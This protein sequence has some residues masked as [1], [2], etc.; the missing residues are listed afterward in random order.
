MANGLD[1]DLKRGDIK[2]VA[3][4]KD[5]LGL[6]CVQAIKII[7]PIDLDCPK[8]CKEGDEDCPPPPPPPPPPPCD[9]EWEDC[10]CDPEVEKCDPPEDKKP[11]L[12]LEKKAEFDE[13]CL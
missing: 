7:I 8:E 2:H 9:P 12:R 4:P 11:E 10:P 6:C 5:G 13:W 3:G 1:G